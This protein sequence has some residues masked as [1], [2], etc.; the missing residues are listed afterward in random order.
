MVDIDRLRLVSKIKG[1]SQE[2]KRQKNRPIK[3]PDKENGY[4]DEKFWA[5][6]VKLELKI[7]A[8]HHML[9]LAFLRN[10]PYKKVERNTKSLPNVRSIFLILQQYAPIGRITYTDPIHPDK[11][12]IRVKMIQSDELSP[13]I[14]FWL[15]TD[16]NGVLK[17]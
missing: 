16:I 1:L 6:R 10:I 15:S 9:A 8:R 13:A 5:Q 2:I 17:Q 4:S 3:S 11:G 14:V 12:G 7:D